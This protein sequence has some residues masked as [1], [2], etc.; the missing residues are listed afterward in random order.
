MTVHDRWLGI[1]L[2]GLLSSVLTPAAAPAQT[3]PAGPV[4]IITQQ[5]AGGGTD[6]AMRMVAEALSKLWG[7]QAVLINQ[8]GAG[9]A[10]AARAVAEAPPD[11]HTL[12]LAL[13]SAFVVLPETQRNLSFNVNDFVPVGFIGEAPMAIAVSPA[14]PVSN[15]AELAALSMKQPG[16]LNAAVAFRG[17]MPHLTTELFASRSGTALTSVHYPSSA[18][19]LSDVISGRV[20]LIV[21][22]LGGPVGSGQVKVLA[23]AS[24]ERLA[25]R[26]DLPTVAETVPG[27]AASGWYVLVAP[28]GTPVAIVDKLNADLRIVLARPDVQQRMADLGSLMRPLSPQQVGDFI[29]SEQKLWAPVVRRLGLGVS[30]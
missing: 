15:I 16:G 24:R 14:L 5:G 10:L 20:Q 23:V 18:Q 26:P 2:V 13:A 22:G 7:Q 29:R 30:Q 8:P 11:G 17:G 27:F 19:S 1:G 21:E 4:R 28:R 3:Y 9:G 6:V 25:A 12:F